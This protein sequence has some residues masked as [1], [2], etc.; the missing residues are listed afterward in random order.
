MD[1]LIR[2]ILEKVSISDLENLI[3]EKRKMLSPKKADENDMIKAY[4]I[5]NH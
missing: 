3:E 1:A 2:S 5:K 4:L